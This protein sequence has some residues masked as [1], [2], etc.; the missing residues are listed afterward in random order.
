[1]K[2]SIRDL[3]WLTVVVALA[4][5]WWL[6]MPPPSLNARVAGHVSVSGAPLPQG[7]VLFHSA[8]GPIVG[9]QVTAGKFSLEQVPIG[10]FS[11]TV[12]GTG[13]PAKYTDQ[14]GGLV[15]EVKEGTNTLDL[16]LR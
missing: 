7:R 13:V 5:G 8:D 2:F 12:D 4:V 15:V 9:A 16:V 1:M 14:N 3:L 6:T 10:K 11:V